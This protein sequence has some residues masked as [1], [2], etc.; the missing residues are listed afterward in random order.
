MQAEV[1]ERVRTTLDELSQVGQLLG[2]GD[3]RP[4]RVACGS[5]GGMIMPGATLCL[6]CWRERFPDAV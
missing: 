4:A 2:V 3:G 1:L 6:Y 5:C